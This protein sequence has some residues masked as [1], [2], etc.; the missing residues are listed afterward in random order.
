MATGAGRAACPPRRLWGALQPVCLTAWGSPSLSVG[1]P[2]LPV[3]LSWGRGSPLRVVPAARGGA[4]GSPVPLLSLPWPGSL[5]ATARLGHGVG[6][7]P[8]GRPGP[9]GRLTGC[10]G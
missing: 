9:P 8:P 6:A 5:G 7:A 3:E 10:G 4:G 1:I 2:I